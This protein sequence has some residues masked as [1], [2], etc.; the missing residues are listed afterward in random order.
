VG[1]WKLQEFFEDGRLGLYDLKSDLGEKHDLASEKPELV[2]ELHAKLAAW[3]SS[4]G[5]PMPKRQT[6]TDQ[7]AKPSKKVKR[8]KKAAKGLSQDFRSL[9]DFGSLPLS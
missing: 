7:P 3:R 5:A 2:K 9:E 8:G 1:D 6:P 4:I